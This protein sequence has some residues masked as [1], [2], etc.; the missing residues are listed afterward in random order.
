MQGVLQRVGQARFIT[1]F[2][3]RSAYWTVPIKKEHQYLTAFLYDNALYQWTR[4][5]YGLRNSGAAF[6]R[7]MQKIMQSIRSFVDSYVD[8]AAVFSDSW[9]EHI[10]HIDLFLQEVKANGLTLNL[11]KSSFAKPQVPFC[12]H[13]IG[14]G[15][16]RIDPRKLEVIRS[17]K[18]PE[19]KKQVRQILGLFSWFRDYLSHFSEHAKPLIDLTRKT[20]PNKV[21][22]TVIEQTALDKLKDLLC[23]AVN[24]PLHVIDW[25]KPFNIYSDA[26]DNTIAGTL[27]QTDENGAERP[28]SFFSRKLSDSQRSWSTIEREAYA[29]LEN[30]N[31][32]RHWIFGYPIHVYSDH[33]PLSFLIDSASKSAKLLRWSL[34]LQAYNIIF[35]YKSGKSEAMSAPDCL[36]RMT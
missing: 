9:D 34:A 8:D 13:I 35:H 4:V 19:T 1:T 23:V 11:Q 29:V 31:H 24:N 20:I 2:D 25:N 30:L 33:N 21:P 5:D 27:S 3:G 10:K 36:S 16:R 12:G 22:W 26:S 32:Y 15:V 18:I 7:V 14:S 6:I 28:I 17:L